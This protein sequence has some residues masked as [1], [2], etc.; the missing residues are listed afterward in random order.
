MNW[1]ADVRTINRNYVSERG[2]RNMSELRKVFY[3]GA[4]MLAIMLMVFPP[5]QSGY[6]FLL[7]HRFV[8]NTMGAKV[9]FPQLLLCQGVIFGI[10]LLVSLLPNKK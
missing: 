6:S 1:T 10:C 7:K 2:R 3:V 9:D 5:F 8:G 4:L